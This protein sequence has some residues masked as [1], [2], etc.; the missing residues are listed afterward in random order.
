MAWLPNDWDSDEY[1]AELRAS[2]DRLLKKTSGEHLEMEDLAAKILAKGR[3]GITAHSELR[4]YLSDSQMAM[5]QS[6]EVHTSLGYP[7]RHIYQGLYKR[8]FNPNSRGTHSS[9]AIP[10]LDTDEGHY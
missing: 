6:R 1:E 4:D 8:V 5:R 2:P 7:E 3:R 10:S 9:N